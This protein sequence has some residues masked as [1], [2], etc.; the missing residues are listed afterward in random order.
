MAG[1][2][3]IEWLYEAIIRFL[4]GP[5]YSTPLMGFIDQQCAIF[6]G[7]E[8]NRLE[9]TETHEKFKQLV[10]T[11]LSDFLA[12]LG[13]DQS[14]FVE[15]VANCANTELNSFV[16]ASIL[17]VDD[18]VQFKAMMTKRNI[19]L[20]NEVFKAHAEAA[21][22][23]EGEAQAPAEE[24]AVDPEDAELQEVLRLSKEQF[25]ADQARSSASAPSAEG[26]IDEE[27]A[28]A[29]KE[30]MQDRKAMD[31]ERERAELEQAIA[32]SLQLEQEQE[33]LLQE[34]AKAPVAEPEPAPL[35]LPKRVVE[36]IEKQASAPP[37]AAPAPAPTPPP[38]AP[39]AS[40]NPAVFVGTA[41]MRASSGAGYSSAVSGLP[42]GEDRK[43]IREA[44]AAAARTQRDLLVNKKDAVVA[45]Q[46]ALKSAPSGLQN[47]EGRRQYLAQQREQLIAKKQAEREKELAEYK[48]ENPE[49][50][51]AASSDPDADAKRLELRNQLA[52]K[53]KQ[54]LI[55]KSLVKLDA[56][57]PPN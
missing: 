2:E 14:K 15:A 29:L 56:F 26:D 20:T 49:K 45:K 21:A 18:F 50:A 44:A 54:E 5:M 4:Q 22:K 42:N 35:P 51:A 40:F 28:K 30:S 52:R 8:E 11:L 13:V 3:D 27:M 55:H 39:A 10:D 33:R 31:L 19:D 43:A 9:Y 41:S 7:E 16:L 34:E 24:P 48:K 36:K 46:D 12:E 32:M 25:E 17:T 1:D 37:P 57:K 6:D 23:K 47:E 38:A 53:L